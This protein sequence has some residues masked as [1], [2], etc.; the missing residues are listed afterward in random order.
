MEEITADP[1]EARAGIEPADKGL[2]DLCGTNR[3]HVP[4][5]T[6]GQGCGESRGS[7][8]GQWWAM[9][10]GTP[11]SHGTPGNEESVSCRF[12]ERL[13]GSNPTLTAELISV[14]YSTT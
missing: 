14:L 12:Q 11:G 4:A 2:A 7:V 3:Q 9:R 6:K 13:V 10:V 8:R 5:D 1:L